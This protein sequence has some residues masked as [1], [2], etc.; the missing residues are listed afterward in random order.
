MLRPNE[1]F[2]AFLMFSPVLLTT[3][4]YRVNKIFWFSFGRWQAICCYLIIQ[5]VNSPESEFF[6]VLEPALFD[7]WLLKFFRR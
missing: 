2:H 4:Y 5:W 6:E 3:R 7:E 1:S